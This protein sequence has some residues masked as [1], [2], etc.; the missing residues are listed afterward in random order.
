MLPLAAESAATT[1]GGGGMN[2]GA[3]GPAGIADAALTDGIG[4]GGGF[5][6]IPAGTRGTMPELFVVTGGNGLGA[7]GGGGTEVCGVAMKADSSSASCCREKWRRPAA[8][9]GAC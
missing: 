2:E 4:A 9:P 6:S 7:S 1:G 5:G 8:I 3:F